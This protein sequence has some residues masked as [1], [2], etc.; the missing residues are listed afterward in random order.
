M[1]KTIITLLALTGVAMAES[2]TL[3]T[4]I[5]YDGELHNGYTD[6]GITGLDYTYTEWHSSNLQDNTVFTITVGELYN[7]DRITSSTFTLD[8]VT[9]KVHHEGWGTNGGRKV[10]LTLNGSDKAVET[11]YSSAGVTNT[12]DVG[13]FTIDNINWT[14]LSKDAVITLTLTMG[15]GQDGWGSSYENTNIPLASTTNGTWSG[16]SLMSIGS[17]KDGAPLVSL[18]ITTV[19]EPATATLSLLALAGLAAR[20][21]RK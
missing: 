8:S 17:V 11:E 21:R 14:D 16:V 5:K 3:T 9:L 20:R 2:L 7:A 6:P 18:G 1:K 13:Y 10:I 4:G 12:D 19:P 15:K